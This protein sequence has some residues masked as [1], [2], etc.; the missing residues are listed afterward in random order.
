MFFNLQHCAF[1]EENEE[2]KNRLANWFLTVAYLHSSF[3]NRFDG[4]CAT[5]CNW[6]WKKINGCHFFDSISNMSNPMVTGIG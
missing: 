6:M 3:E 2:L 4:A 5:S 1:K